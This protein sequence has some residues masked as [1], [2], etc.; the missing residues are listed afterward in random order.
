METAVSMVTDTNAIGYLAR[1]VG[2]GKSDYIITDWQGNELGAAMITAKWKITSYLSSTMMQV[3]AR[4]NGRWYT[5][6]TMGE[7]MIWRGKAMRTA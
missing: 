2:F 5:G 3:E 6:R 7:G 4:I 1:R